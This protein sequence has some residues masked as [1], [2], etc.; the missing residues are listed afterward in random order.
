MSKPW[1]PLLLGIFVMT[2]GCDDMHD[3]VAIQPQEAPRLSAPAEAVP[4]TGKERLIFGQQ[5]NNPQANSAESRQ[6][7]AALYTI[8]CATCHGGKDNYPNQVGGH[9]NPPPPNLRDGHLAGYDEATLYQMFSLGFGR[10]PAF[11]LRLSVED[12]WH[13]VNYLRSDD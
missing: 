2:A 3:Q 5:Q 11:Q 1:L 6:R 9:F 13:L 7:G 12:R 10:M 8:N 4:V